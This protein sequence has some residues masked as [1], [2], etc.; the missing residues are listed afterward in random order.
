MFVSDCMPLTVPNGKKSLNSSRHG[1]DVTITCN[2]GYTLFG[3]PGRQT[4]LQGEWNGKMPT[5]IAGKLKSLVPKQCVQK[6]QQGPHK[7]KKNEKDNQSVHVY[8]FFA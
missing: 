8:K 4:C 7:R 1:T 3:S 5:C 6:V 2:E